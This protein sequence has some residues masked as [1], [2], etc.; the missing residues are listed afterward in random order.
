V[1]SKLIFI[2]GDVMNRK[3]LALTLV[4]AII[5]GGAVVFLDCTL[6]GN[7]GREAKN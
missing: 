7:D 6:R 2:E 1:K 5:A 4:L 3:N